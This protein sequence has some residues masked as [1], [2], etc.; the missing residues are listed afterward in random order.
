[1]ISRT[2]FHPMM[3][4]RIVSMRLP[5]K[6]RKYQRCYDLKTRMP[7]EEYVWLYEAIK[8]KLAGMGIHF[9]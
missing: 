8:E 9:K 1:M 4:L 6:G 3:L 5:L 2:L 7:F